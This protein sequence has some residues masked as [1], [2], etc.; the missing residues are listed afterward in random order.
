MNLLISACL[1]GINC[2]HDGRIIN[3]FNFEKLL[4]DFN[5]IPV[6]PEQLGGLTTPRALSFFIF[7]DGNDTIKGAKNLKNRNGIDVSENFKRGAEETL[8]ICKIFNIKYAVLKEK[9]PSCG[10]NKIYL[11]EKL[12][13]GQGVTAAIL[14]KNGIH[15]MPENKT[16]SL[17]ER[18]SE[19]VQQ[20]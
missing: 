6:C 10:L 3:D 15:I 4:M 9:S 1:L 17:N 14:S 2:R 11:K 8:K 16:R 13:D 18:K 5:L 7:G 20:E 19:M 12:V